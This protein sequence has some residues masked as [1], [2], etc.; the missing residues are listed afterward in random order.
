MWLNTMRSEREGKA[1]RNQ[2]HAVPW[3]R[4]LCVGR[5][6]MCGVRIVCTDLNDSNNNNNGDTESVVSEARAKIIDDTKNTPKYF[7]FPIFPIF[8][9]Q[10]NLDALI[11]ILWLFFR[12]SYYF[13]DLFHFF[14]SIFPVPLLSIA[15]TH[16]QCTRRRSLS[17]ANSQI[18][19]I[20]D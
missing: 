11:P 4:V 9:S 10:C 2:K 18:F 17:L 8:G 13:T 16:T 6:K 7:F 12:F 3:Y 20:P 1:Q 5:M 15:V 19:Q 14:C